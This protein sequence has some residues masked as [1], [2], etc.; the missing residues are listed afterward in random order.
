LQIEPATAAAIAKHA[1]HLARISPERIAEELRLMLTPAATRIRAWEMLHELG[2][3]QV[4]FRLLQL[5][6][7]GPHPDVARGRKTLLFDRV[8]VGRTVPFGL[9][10]AA[11]SLEYAAQGLPHLAEWP[12]IWERVTV[13]AIV[14]SARQALR[15][16]NDEADA[17]EGTL[18]GLEILLRDRSMGVV[19]LKRFLARPT[20]SL[21]RELLAALPGEVVGEDYRASVQKRLEELEQTEFAPTPLVSGDDLTAAGLKP[22]PVFKRVLDAVYD[23]QLE[24]RVRTKEEA[25]K[26][27]L[28][29]ARLG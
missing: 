12:K 17:L 25:L 15:I 14:R 13:R 21:S 1:A 22:G 6:W 8:A 20:A 9:A 24:D 23:A 4:I 19:M 7:N 3:D 28:E 29:L 16:S 27:A 10:I 5:P 11:A 26:L 18:Y 2:L